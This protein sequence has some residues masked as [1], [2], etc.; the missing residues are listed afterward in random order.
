MAA[1]ADL[2]ITL[3]VRMGKMEAEL[4]KAVDALKSTQRQAQTTASQVSGLGSS[5]ATAAGSIESGARRAVT[6][7]SGVTRVLGPLAALMATIGVGTGIASALTSISSLADEAGSLGTTANELLAIRQG[8]EEAGGNA[9]QATAGLTRFATAM[10]EAATGSREAQQTMFD[11]GVAYR[12]TDGSVRTVTEGLEDL[13]SK[14]NSSDSLTE[15]LALASAAV[16]VRNARVFVAA[17]EEM[18]GSVGAAVTKLREMGMA[19]EENTAGAID[20]LGTAFNN[21]GRTIS[22]AIGNAVAQAEPQIRTLIENITTWVLGAITRINSI[23]AQWRIDAATRAD[24]GLQALERQAAPA[25]AELTRLRGALASIDEQMDTL[26]QNGGQRGFLGAV[27]GTQQTE[28]E[29]RAAREQA[30]ALLEDA[31]RANA[32]LIRQLE[33]RRNV[34]SE[35]ARINLPATP[36]SGRGEAVATTPTTRQPPTAPPPTHTAAARETDAQ[37]EA[38]RLLADSYRDLTKLMERS[39]DPLDQLAGKLGDVTRALREQDRA[40]EA[41]RQAYGHLPADIAP[42]TVSFEV[43]SNVANKAAEDAAKAMQ[44]TG[45]SAGAIMDAVTAQ[46][47]AFAQELQRAG[48]ITTEQVDQMVASAQAATQRVTR[49]GF[50]EGFASGAGVDTQTAAPDLATELG[51]GA[52]QISVGLFDQ[53]AESLDKVASG[54]QSAGDAMREFALDFVKAVTMMIVKALALAAVQAIIRA[55]AGPSGAVLPAG[56]FGPPA[57]GGSFGG[58]LASGGPVSPGRSYIVGERGPEWFTPSGTGRIVANGAMAGMQVNV[59]NN[60]PGVV[61][62][63]TTNDDRTIAIAVNLSRQRVAADFGE[64]TRT[65]YGPYAESLSARYAMRRRV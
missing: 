16:G 31:Q 49:T 45:S 29:L 65:G 24:T 8:F 3:S 64:G 46:V 22:A 20:R 4:R 30:V 12:N 39:G 11:L 42:L 32:P 7:L 25:I 35:I 26:R 5:F 14:I 36:E 57:P 19:I 15:K 41:Y 52:G 34:V 1:S 2:A 18:G 50:F 37:R 27:L 28:Q 59:V 33:A 43:L 56:Q 63:Q 21:L 51:K 17:I 10:G 60:A 53:I 40:F 9:G 62:D 47:T 54:A 23:A 13:I 61:I 55:F 6:S 44:A 58:A 38:N 48:R